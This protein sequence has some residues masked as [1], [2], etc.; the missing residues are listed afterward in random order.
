M[1]IY[2]TVRIFTMICLL[3]PV[4]VQQVSG[5]EASDLKL[6]QPCGNIT[7]NDAAEILGVSSETVKHTYSEEMKTCSYMV[8]F[9]KMINYSLY[10]ADDATSAQSEMADVAQGL[11]MLANCRAVENVGESAVYCNGDKAERFLVQK[12]KIWIDIR[13][14]KGL[15]IMI[16]VAN[17]ILQQR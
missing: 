10:F 8:A 2:K 13:S 5:Q 15:D 16:R 7:I 11:K 6:Q 17:K 4:V 3:S 12:N 1:M 9:D 14:P